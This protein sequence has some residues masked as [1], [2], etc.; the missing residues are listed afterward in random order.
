MDTR[1]SVLDI[2]GLRC[3]L[4]IK[5]GMLTGRC[6]YEVSSPGERPGLEMLT[7]E[8]HLKSQGL[9][10]VLGNS[11]KDHQGLSLQALPGRAEKSAKKEKQ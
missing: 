3:L 9:F 6:V 4:D 5:V 11:D 1:N 2:P 7:Q 10:K 8:S